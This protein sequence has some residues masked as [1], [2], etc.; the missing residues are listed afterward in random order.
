MFSYVFK[1]VNVLIILS[2]L[3]SSCAT[4]RLT[5]SNFTKIEE[6][7]TTE[8]EVISLLGEPNEVKSSSLDTKKIGTMLGIDKIASLLGFKTLPDKPLSGT[9]AIW[10]TVDAQANIIFYNGKVLSKKLIKDS[11]EVLGHF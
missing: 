9:T 8:E 4:P 2:F 3:L 1:S 10:K 11:S 6:G 7:V 5:Y